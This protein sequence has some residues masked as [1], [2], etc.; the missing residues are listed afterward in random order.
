M[1][2]RNNMWLQT[3]P[4]WHI[5]ISACLALQYE[6][7]VMNC[8]HDCSYNYDY[9]FWHKFLI[10]PMYKYASNILHFESMHESGEKS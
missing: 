3:K 5:D 8:F 1:N 6:R 2:I 7:R 9:I 10:Q 4:K